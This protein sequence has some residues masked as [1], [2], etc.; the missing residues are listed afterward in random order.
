MGRNRTTRHA[1]ARKSIAVSI[2]SGE[3][4]GECLQECHDL[5]LLLIRQAEVTGGHIYVVPHF[6]HRPAVYFFDR[7]IRA[8]SGS[9]V[10]RK[11]RFVARVVEVDELLQALDV[12]IVKEPLLKIRPGRLGGGTPCRGHSHIARR[13]HLHLAV[14]QRCKLSPTCVRVGPGTGTAS[15]EGPHAQVSKGEAEGIPNE[16]KGIWRGLI[17]DSIPGIQG[18]A[19]IGRAEAGEQRVYLGGLAVVESRGGRSGSSSIQVA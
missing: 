15:E 4:I 8:M 5:V 18:Q 12:A 6:W 11:P 16:A 7:P 2:R 3:T 13:R 14:G 19:F 17:I 9:N 10:E 1:S